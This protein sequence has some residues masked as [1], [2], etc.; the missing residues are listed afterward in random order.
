MT[1]LDTPVG[2]SD[3]AAH[4]SVERLPNGNP[5]VSPV[6]GDVDDVEDAQEVVG[7][8]SRR[9]KKTTEVFK[10]EEHKEM[11]NLE[12]MEGAGERLRD[13]PNGTLLLAWEDASCI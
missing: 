9:E 11:K 2:I 4:P 13:I 10:V 5:I 8:R 7:R 12:F 6:Q 3:P 1:F